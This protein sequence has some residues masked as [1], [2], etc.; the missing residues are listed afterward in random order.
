M[1]IQKLQN[2]Q[3]GPAKALLEYFDLPTDD[4][5]SSEIKLFGVVRNNVLVGCIGYEKFEELGLLRSLAVSKNHQGKGIAN[6]LVIFLERYIN[7][8]G[9][10]YLFLLTETA[11]SYFEKL[12]YKVLDR[13]KTPNGL[14]ASSEFS[15]LCP[16]TAVLMMKKL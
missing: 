12:D 6:E 11:E 8:Q 1:K 16:E 5:D 13:S 3:I 4:L 7:K 9:V 14:K 2:N 15:H 10:D